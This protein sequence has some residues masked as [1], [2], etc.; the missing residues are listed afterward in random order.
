MANSPTFVE[1][2]LD[3]LSLA[4]PVQAR[5]MFGGHGVYHRG[6]MF[7]LI[8]D[9]DLFLKTD[10]ETV[11][12]FLD[13]G[14]EPWIY[15]GPRGPERSS[16]YRPPDDAHEDAEAMAPWAK[17]AIDAALRAQAAKAERRGPRA[18][19]ATAARATKASAARATKASAARATKAS[20]GPPP[21]KAAPRAR[22]GRSARAGP[23][24]PRAR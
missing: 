8:D 3:L 11:R 2:A 7:G 23:R 18:A 20:A 14:C 4:G 17:L 21:S 9:D 13:A 24:A 22:G 10:A 16:Y 5:A 1:H 15:V 19:K 12:R 6:A